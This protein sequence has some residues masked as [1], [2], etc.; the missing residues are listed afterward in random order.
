MAEDAEGPG[1]DAHVITCRESGPSASVEVG[2]RRRDPV[3]RSVRAATRPVA[4]LLAV[5]LGAG[6]LVAVTV[7][8]PPVSAAT[9]PLVWQRELPG[10]AIRESSPA[11]VDLTGS[12]RLDVVVGAHDGRVWGL[13][14]GDGGDAPG[15]PQQ[16]GDAVDSS[17]AVADLDGDGRSDLVIGSGSFERASGALWSFGRDGSVRFWRPLADLDFGAPSVHSAPALGDLDGDGR[18]DIAAT[19]LGIQS[20]WQLDAA[21]NALPG[22]PFM[23]DDTS[24]ASPALADVDAD[25][26]LDMVVGGDASAGGLVDH[27]GGMVRALTR[28]GR[29]LWEVRVDDIVRSSP[30]IGD[31]DRD[32]RPEVV[33]GVGD[34]YGGNDSTAIYAVDLATGAPKWRRGLDGVALGSPALADVDGDGD[35]EVAVGTFPS[36]HGRGRGQS[37]YVLDGATGGDTPHFP[38]SVESGALGAVT[39]A[40]VDGDGFQDLF[41]PTGAWIAVV[42]GRTGARLLNLAENTRVGFASSAAIADVDGDGV[43]DV[44]A[45]GTRADGAGVVFRWRLGPQ[46]R[47]GT[48]GWPQFRRDAQRTGSWLPNPGSAV[49][50]MARVP[51]GSG[52]W[53]VAADG[54]VVPHGGAPTVGSAPTGLAR[55]VVGMAATPSGRG[56]WLVAADG[57][58]FTFGDARFFGSTGAVRLNRPIVGMTAS[59]TGAGY[60]FVASD[61]GIFTFGDARFLGSEGAV[62]LNRPVVGMAATPSGAGYWL[63]ASD[64]GIF[65]HGDAAFLGS[66]GAIR[67]ARPITGMTTTRSGRGYAFVATDGGIFTFG[68]APFHGSTGAAPPPSPVVGMADDGTGG[69]YWLVTAAGQVVGFG[70]ARP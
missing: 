14:A 13:R 11:L 47:L 18:I 33:F 20:A 34:Y 2:H 70:S 52:Y 55:P 49:V 5:V 4:I 46:A 51:G 29:S 31:V 48:L 66:T 21:G 23:W 9:L 58:I 22:Y 7:A 17:A 65:T 56:Y 38:Q 16:V 37:V 62:P 30:S 50:G 41:V 63:V 53:T 27:R 57:G 45:A 64:G 15:W 24:F 12:G 26:V 54:R 40:D 59:P 1:Y 67:L 36:N 43:L 10:A 6:A 19:S 68:D 44:V 60:W 8:A 35:L 69:G 39:T 3:G 32:G 61:G 25:G 42:D 28:D